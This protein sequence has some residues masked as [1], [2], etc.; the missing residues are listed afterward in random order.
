MIEHLVLARTVIGSANEVMADAAVWIRRGVVA[1]IGRRRD[2]DSSAIPRVDLGEAVL[3]P[4]LVNA[5]T[6]LALSGL[7]SARPRAVG[8]GP[9]IETMARRASKL[10]A[11]ALAAGYDRGVRE[12]IAYG[13]TTV[14]DIVPPQAIAS[15]RGSALAGI[16]FLE[17]LG[18]DRR[19]DEMRLP[20]LLPG[21]G[22]APHAPY[23]TSADL[24]RGAA[25]LARAM[26]MRL[27]LHVAESPEEVEFVR[28]G[29]GPLASLLAA[30]GR[31]PRAYRAPGTTTI[32]Y[33]EKLGVFA[34]PTLAV[35]ATFATAVDLDRLRRARAT[36]VPCPRSNR[37]L[38]G[39]SRA[40]LPLLRAGQ[41]VALGTDSLASA[42]TL[43]ILDELRDARRH[44]PAIATDTLLDLATR[45]GAAALGV[46]G[47]AI[48]P[49]RRADLAAFAVRV[50]DREPAEAVLE[51]ANQATWVAIGGRVRLGA[52]P[53]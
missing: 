21:D 46:D 52:R 36:I 33:L 23:S 27:S 6:H 49:G 37:A 40:L 8:F 14:G 10:D 16:R 1:A 22:L 25:T 20:V 13:V 31:L 35:H 34:G 9:W 32:A 53:I 19:A 41:L 43:S 4:G 39:E 30:R 7:A 2:L 29:G 42:P 50:G 26:A 12:S 24:Y 44:E 5:H 47:G 38:T 28:T 51:D 17:V 11:A 15:A 3:M 18:F 45:G 48:T